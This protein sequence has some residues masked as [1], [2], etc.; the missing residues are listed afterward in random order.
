MAVDVARI[1][2][3]RIEELQVTDITSKAIEV[4]KNNNK[5]KFV[6]KLLPTP[7]FSTST[8][9]ADGQLTL[10]SVLCL[11]MSTLLEEEDPFRLPLQLLSCASW[12][13]Q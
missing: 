5:I 8:P 3:K 1:L 2:T 10:E 13:V 11:E 12:C 4:L 9:A 7:S 6:N